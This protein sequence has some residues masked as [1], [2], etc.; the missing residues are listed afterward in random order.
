M[1]QI[2]NTFASLIVLVLELELFLIELY[3]FDSL[4]NYASNLV[5]IL[6]AIEFW[7]GNGTHKI[8]AKSDE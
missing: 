5:K 4:G 3:Q 1:Y 2:A 8:S 7:A 6:C